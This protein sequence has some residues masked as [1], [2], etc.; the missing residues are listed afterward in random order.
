MLAALPD[1]AVLLAAGSPV[2]CVL[3]FWPAATNPSISS[4]TLPTPRPLPSRWPTPVARMATVG[5]AMVLLW[6][7]P[8][9]TSG[10]CSALLGY[11]VI[12]LT[13]QHV[14]VRLQNSMGLHRHSRGCRLVA[15][16]AFAGRALTALLLPSAVHS[17]CGTGQ[18]IAVQLPPLVCGHPVGCLLAWLITKMV[19][20]VIAID[21]PA[22]SPY[23]S[24]VLL[25]SEG[26]FV[27]FICHACG[28]LCLLFPI[29][30]AC[31]HTTFGVTADR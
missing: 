9:N 8:S 18:A 26:T 17:R 2:G 14:R 16:L 23:L 1:G 6:G 10:P 24:Y 25:L 3:L 4:L 11:D 22:I 21:L 31:Q 5:N 13:L 30:P 19:N 29:L 7:P 12:V 15:V 27:Q 28:S 20:M